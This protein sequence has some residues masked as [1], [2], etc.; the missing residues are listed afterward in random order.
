MCFTS[1]FKS[2]FV[3][4]KSPNEHNGR[5]AYRNNSVRLYQIQCSIR[6]NSTLVTRQTVTDT[7]F[8]II[9]HWQTFH[10]LFLTDYPCGRYGGKEAPLMICSKLGGSVRT[11]IQRQ[12]ITIGIRIVET[13]HKRC[14]TGLFVVR[15]C[16]LP[17]T[18]CTRLANCCSRTYPC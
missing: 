18:D 3:F 17:Q 6:V 15:I 1:H 9:N 14:E 2:G 7:K 16:P 11:G 10:K 13:S 12:D 5:V 8:Q 4:L